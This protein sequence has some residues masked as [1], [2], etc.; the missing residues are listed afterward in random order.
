MKIYFYISVAASALCLLLSIVLFWEGGANQGLQNEVQAQ[1][2]KLQQQQDEINK[3]NA[4]SQ[5]VG[6]NLLRD[7]AVSS[8]KDEKMKAL[9]SKHGYTVNVA[10]PTPG[11]SPAPGAPTPAR[12]SEPGVIKP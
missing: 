9:L 10:S 11:A 7:M 1:Q 3:G 4:I 6:P 8:T 2:A 12:A 5:Q